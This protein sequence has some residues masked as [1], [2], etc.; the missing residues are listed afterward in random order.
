MSTRMFRYI[1]PVDDK[2]HGLRLSHRQVP[3]A[4]WERILSVRDVEFWCEDTAG[5]PTGV[6]WFQVFGT[7]HPLPPDARWVGTCARTR[8]GLVWHLYEVNGG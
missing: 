7:G 6:R 3:D 5:A 1:V 2:A 4:D 8:S